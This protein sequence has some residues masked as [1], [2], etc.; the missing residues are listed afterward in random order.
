[1]KHDINNLTQWWT[2][3]KTKHHLRHYDRIY[4][5]IILIT[6]LS[7]VVFFVFCLAIYKES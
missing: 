1:M 2:N 4:G 3:I 5:H 7:T 6:T